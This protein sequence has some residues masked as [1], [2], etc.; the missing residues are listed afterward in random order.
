MII[1]LYA[2][3]PGSDTEDGHSLTPALTDNFTGLLPRLRTDYLLTRAEVDAWAQGLT[4]GNV[5]VC[6]WE[7]V[8][9]NRDGTNGDVFTG[10]AGCAQELA[11]ADVGL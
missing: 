2:Y 10:S 9:V 7:A 11:D 1:K 4:D 5:D 6:C 8:L 3:G